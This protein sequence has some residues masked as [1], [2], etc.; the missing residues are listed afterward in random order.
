V[1]VKGKE[2]HFKPI[3]QH[4]DEAAGDACRHPQC[5][6]G[7]EWLGHLRDENVDGEKEA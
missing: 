4:K 6:R 7:F 3:G 5:L 2:D 1:V